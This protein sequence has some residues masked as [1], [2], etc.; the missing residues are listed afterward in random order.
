MDITTTLIQSTATT[1]VSAT[2][3]Y[4]PS[5][6]TRD[7]S[8]ICAPTTARVPFLFLALDLPP[9]PV[10]VDEFQQNVIP[11]VGI[12]GLL[13]KYS[14]DHESEEKERKRKFQVQNLPPFLIFHIH[15]IHLNILFFIFCRDL[16]RIIGRLKRIIQL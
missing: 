8:H 4:R 5:S 2:T 3:M 13:E 15:V 14:G 7:A 10:F 12:Q 6:T 16:E 1:Q 11:Q 9:L